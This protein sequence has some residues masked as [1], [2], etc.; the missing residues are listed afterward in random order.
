MPYISRKP[1]LIALAALAMLISAKS[2]AQTKYPEPENATVRD[3][4]F[5]D[6]YFGLTYP[7]PAG[8]VEDIKGPEPSASG[9]YS[10]AALKPRDDFSA[11]IQIAA[12]DNFFAEPPF[13]GAADFLAA[14]KRGLDASLAASDVSAAEFAGLH[15]AR[16]DYSGA[17]LIHAVFAAEIRCHTVLFTITAGSQERIAELAGSLQKITYTEHAWQASWESGQAGAWPVCVPEAGYRDHIVHTVDPV[18]TGPRYASVPV[19][20]VIG[21]DGKLEHI[22]AIAGDPEQIRSLKDALQKWEFKPYLVQSQP[23]EVETGIL[24]QF[25]RP[26]QPRTSR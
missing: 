25:P 11:T 10:L 6:A 5:R 8:W 12:Q 14:M 21:A 13:N 24:F 1:W 16:L 20:L 26:P 2:G 23:A 7:L 19:R 4:V 18:M 9:F 17:G 22:H 3:G 15:F